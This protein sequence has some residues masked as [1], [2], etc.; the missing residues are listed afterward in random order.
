[1]KNKNKIFKIIE[2]ILKDNVKA[3]ILGNDG[4][5]RKLSP[6]EEK[7]RLILKWNWRKYNFIGTNDAV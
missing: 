2:I 3:R 7:F 1:M 4:I 6:A 5:Y